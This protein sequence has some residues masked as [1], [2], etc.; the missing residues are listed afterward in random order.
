MEELVNKKVENLVKNKINSKNTNTTAVTTPR[1]TKK[2]TFSV[3]QN[4]LKRNQEFN[5]LREITGE[6][7]ET[8]KKRLVTTSPDS[9]AKTKFRFDPKSNNT[10]K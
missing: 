2:T 5:A 6:L 8:D 9:G 10:N 4:K 3:I 1:T 7:K